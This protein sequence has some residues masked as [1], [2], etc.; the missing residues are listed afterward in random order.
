MNFFPFCWSP[1][2]SLSGRTLKRELQRVTSLTFCRRSNMSTA[3]TEKRFQSSV[4]AEVTRLIL[5]SEM[6]RGCGQGNDRQRN[7]LQRASLKTRPVGGP[8]LQNAVAL[9]VSCRP[10][11]LT[12]RLTGVFKQALSNFPIPLPN[13]PLP[14]DSPFRWSSSFSL[15]GRTLKRELQR[16]TSLTYCR[17]SNMSVFP[18]RWSSSFSLSGPF[19]WSSSFSLS[20]RTLKRELQRAA[21]SANRQ[22]AIVN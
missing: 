12:R 2:F 6:R 19:R 11:A 5:K 7:K 9:A 15:S 8:G 1:S 16:V 10:R 20:G 14:F 17:R 4:A 18:S 22:S 13:I 21:L 3:R